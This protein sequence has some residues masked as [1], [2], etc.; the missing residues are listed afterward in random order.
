MTT[1][2]KVAEYLTSI[3]I[4][5]TATYAGA[6]VRE[7][8]KCDVWRCKLANQEFEFFTGLGHRNPKPV[9]PSAASLLYS[10]I[11]DRSAGTQ[12]FDNWCAEIGYDPDSRKALATYLA[13]QANAVKLERVFT[14]EQ[15]A[16][17]ETMLEDY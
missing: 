2:E 8:W 13:C 1:D 15:L 5:Y 6:T 3:G 11:L 10:L 16:E 17:L 7:N 9:P 12:T 14:S 4:P